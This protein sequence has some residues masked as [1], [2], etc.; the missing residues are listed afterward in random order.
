MA[1]NYIPTEGKLVTMLIDG[2]ETPFDP[3]AENAE[4]FETVKFEE[5]P[6]SYTDRGIDNYRAAITVGPDGIIDDMSVKAAVRGGSFDE[7]GAEGI[8]V[9]STSDSFTAVLLKNG[10]YKVKD[11]TFNFVTKS[12]GSD[13]SD[14]TGY[15]S[16]FTMFDHSQL[17]LDNVDI[18]SIGVAKPSIYCDEHSDAVI[19]NS[20]V[21]V[22]GGF[23]YDGYV[24]SADCTVMVAPPWVLGITG[25]AR[26]TN[27]MGTKSSTTVVNCD[28]KANQW[29]VL[30]TDGG[31]DMQLVVVDSDLTL[32]GENVPEVD[33]KNP[34]YKRYGSGYGTYIIG[35][36]RE[37]FHGV[38]FRVGTYA[39]I[40]RGG[41]A[42]YKSSKGFVSV[43]SPTT[44]ETLYAGEGQGRITT[45]ESDA[46]GF[47]AH[48][49]ANFTLTEGTVVNSPYASFLMKAGGGIINIED[50]TQLNAENGVLVQIIDDDDSLVGVDWSAKYELTFFT[51]FNEKEGWPSENGQITSCMELP[52]PPPMPEDSY[53]PFDGADQAPPEFNVNFNAKDVSLKGDLYNGS[54][55]FGGAAKQL[56]VRLGKGSELSGCISATE[57]MHVDENGRQNTHFTSQQYYYLGHVANR[58]Y[59]NGD[60]SVE[61][62]LEDGAVWN[63]AGEGLITSLCVGEG[64]VFNGCASIDGKPIDLKPGETYT[65]LIKV[66]AK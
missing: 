15:G 22:A 31:T 6:C 29:G 18:T 20:R 40:S 14:F 9:D 25:N 21:K 33:L 38:N 55:Y 37:E 16:V 59:F 56:Y 35:N 27:L 43:T 2:V 65:G 51:E 24:N 32:M 60:N 62:V 44:G 39:S 42:I 17:E 45:V 11:S 63:V 5:N 4:F 28:Y 66:S 48:G 52:P 1:E 10:K 47:M 3:A 58:P 13:V 49:G 46:F 7:N 57:V 8:T 26:G 12:D 34:Y 19:K 23:L 64:C 50:G 41:S 30:S 54:G 53:D 36:A 61:V